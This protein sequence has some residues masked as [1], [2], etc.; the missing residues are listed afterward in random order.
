MMNNFVNI[1]CDKICKKCDFNEYHVAVLER[2]QHIR[3]P[4]KLNDNPAVPNALV[5]VLPSP[6][7]EDKERISEL[8]T[9]MIKNY[10]R[11]IEH[12]V[13]VVYS[14][15]CNYSP[16][17]SLNK[18]NLNACNDHFLNMLKAI[19]SRHKRMTILA[20]GGKSITALKLAGFSFSDIGKTS[21]QAN[22][23]TCHPSNVLGVNVFC[24][25]GFDKYTLGSNN[26]NIWKTDINYMCDFLM[27]NIVEKKLDYKIINSKQE[28]NDLFKLIR[29]KLKSD[30]TML[31]AIDTETTS[32]NIYGRKD[33][34]KLLTFQISFEVGTGYTIPVMHKDIDN[35]PELREASIKFL[36]LL[37]GNKNITFIAHNAM[38]DFRVFPRLGYKYHEIKYDTMLMHHLYEAIELHGLNL[39][40]RR[41]LAYGEY[42][43]PLTEY[44]AANKI[45]NYG[46]IPLSLLGEYGAYDAA[47]TLELFYLFR[48]ELKEMNLWDFYHEHTY[49]SLQVL[50]GVSK[51]GMPVDYE[52]LKRYYIEY[53]EEMNDYYMNTIAVL[54]EVQQ[55]E[56]SL[57][58]NKDYLEMQEDPE[59]YR[60]KHPRKKPKYKRFN[61]KSNVDLPIL[62][63]E[64]YNIPVLHKTPKGN[65]SYNKDVREY[66]FKFDKINNPF[67]V[68]LSIVHIL[69]TYMLQQHEYA[70]FIKGMYFG[71][72]IDE[73]C[74]VHPSI[75]ISGTKTGR[76][77]FSSPN[78]QQLPSGPMLLP[79]FKIKKLFK[80]TTGKV[81]I[82]ADYSQA[83]LRVLASVAND[84]AMLEAFNDGQDIHRSTA[85]KVMGVPLDEVT[86]EQRQAAKAINF[87]LVYGLGLEAF[88]LDFYNGLSG[89]D[90][91]AGEMY[92]TLVNEGYTGD[93]SPS[94]RRK[95]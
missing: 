20:S 54:P 44:K 68:D 4:V 32:L 48:E 37:L 23:L 59:M 40:T 3:K 46:D 30:K 95:K 21:V 42:E 64:Y 25:V 35:N 1:P 93:Y 74:R 6:F 61:P 10:P 83:E 51:T 69:H 53:A 71:D 92:Q 60:A 11:F 65:P 66:L 79:P 57:P 58:A 67:G 89:Q 81:I 14:V 45:T 49:P 47:A 12:Q 15:A 84:S 50:L 2:E 80:P 18:G 86:A 94:H 43:I 22:R 91:K 39:L 41:F 73:N 38:Y 62:L 36:R 63:K 16:L 26:E 85:S 75:N 56:K 7:V 78:L 90:D 82:Q 13:Y 17:Q 70:N 9:L 72:I 87:G 5:I 8:K 88:A 76:I 24:T 29:E 31:M 77:S 34:I 19:K 33:K 27:G 55:Y 28:L 52:E